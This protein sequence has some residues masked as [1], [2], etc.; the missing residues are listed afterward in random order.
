MKKRSIRSRKAMTLAEICIVLAVIAIVSTVVASFCLFAN[1]RAVAS[2]N[3]LQILNEVSA[4]EKV[5]EQ[6]V[7]ANESVTVMDGALTSGDNSISLVDGVLTAD[8]RDDGDPVTLDCETVEEISF[9]LMTKT[10]DMLVF[11]RVTC[12]IPLAN[13]ESKSETHVFCVNSRLGEAV[14]Q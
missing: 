13:G 9:E 10:G 11:C 1:H 12:S 4:I 6:F 14:A 8:I 3:R 2:S 7:D 5:V